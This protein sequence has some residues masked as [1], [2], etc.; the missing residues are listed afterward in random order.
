MSYRERQSIERLLRHVRVLN[1][2]SVIA[3]AA[4]ELLQKYAT[5]S[6]LVNDAL[7]AATAWVKSLPLLTRNQKHYD[8]I[9]EIDLL[10]PLSFELP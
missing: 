6:L 8:F 1:V 9:T 3:A 7:I 4:S 5:H 2:D 10:N